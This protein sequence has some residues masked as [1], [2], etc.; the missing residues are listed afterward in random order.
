MVFDTEGVPIT[1][2]VTHVSSGLDDLG[3]VKMDDSGDVKMNEKDESNLMTIEQRIEKLKESLRENSSEDSEEDEEE[4]EE[5]IQDHSTFQILEPS[6]NDDDLT[7]IIYQSGVYMPWLREGM[8]HTYDFVDECMRQ[9]QDRPLLFI[10]DSFMIQFFNEF[11]DLV[12][13]RT[14]NEEI[15]FDHSKT[16]HEYL[17]TQ[18]ENLAKLRE[19]IGISIFFYAV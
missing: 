17:S 19:K 9:F 10:G 12:L 16:R 7:K 8:P 4:E 11:V 13:H 2:L 18:C 1:K 3:D 6:S 14:N 5:K 15:E